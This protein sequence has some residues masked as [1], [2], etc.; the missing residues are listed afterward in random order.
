MPHHPVLNPN[1]PDKKRKVC[2][3]DSKFRGFSLD[4]TLLAR[5]DLLANL[6]GNLARFRQKP[7][8]LSADIEEMFLQVEVRA[9]DRECLRF[10]WQTADKNIQTYR[11]NRHIYGVRSSP[12]CANFALQNC[13]RDNADDF[14]L[15]SH[16]AQ[17]NFYM[18]DLLISVVTKDEAIILKK[19]LTDMLARGGLKLTMWTKNFDE[20]NESEKALTILG[21]E[22]NNVTDTL[23]VCRGHSFEPKPHWRQRKVLSVVSSVFDS[24]GFLAPF[25]IRGRIILKRKWQT[26]GQQLDLN[27]SDNLN[28][29][30]HSWVPELNVGEPFEVPRWYRT[31]DEAV[32]NELNVSVMFQ[33][34]PFARWRI[35]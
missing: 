26:R 10:L 29:D 27:I 21:M 35:L 33:K 22:W 5:P 19:D 25:V 32:K 6:K 8:A 7:F 30:F 14:V 24:L 9:E 31:T 11:C 28:D 2:N 3:A 13:A 12:T 20:K 4:D 23:K 17:I 15:A 18:H 16:V 1:K 34:T